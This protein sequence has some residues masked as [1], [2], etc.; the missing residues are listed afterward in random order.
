MK[1]LDLQIAHSVQEIG[2]EAWDHLSG[3]RPFASYRWYHFGETVLVD[4]T[5]I[6][7]ILTRDGE[8]VARATFWLKR[9]EP[10]PIPSKALRH[11]IE[12]MLHRWPLL[13][14]RSPLS[15]APGLI[16]PEPPLRDAAL[17]TIAQ[18]AQELAQRHRA[19]F[20]VFDYLQRHETEWA[21]W[22][23]AFLPASG[24]DPGSRL[25]IVWPDFESYLK[26]LSKSVRK[27]YR[28]HRNRAADLGVV[29][30]PHRA[31]TAVDE[32]LV[33]IRN[34]EGEHNS[35]PNPWARGMLENAGLVDATWLLAEKD[36]RLVGCGL[37]LGDSGARFLTLL[38]LD[39]EV[40][41]AYFQ[42]FYAAI[43]SAIEEGLQI[44]RGGSGA[45]DLKQRLGFQME[46]N[47]HVVFAGRGAL[48]QR[49]GRWAAGTH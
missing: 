7:L 43:R 1:E 21:G 30:T 3:S 14:C 45:Y 29:V 13:V 19:S 22:P 5:P 49:L 48:F 27:D 24:M 17:E 39:Y 25:A 4:D 12:T 23:D 6:Y 40:R 11:L 37:L 47:V 2:Q 28:R 8:A 31:V 46:P 35:T 36:S 26:H 32:A 34:V 18:C 42:L 44:L 15:S 9:Q 20:L 10:L 16:L 41:Y 38:G 33:L